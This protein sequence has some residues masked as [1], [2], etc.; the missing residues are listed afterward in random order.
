MKKALIF[1]LAIFIGSSFALFTPRQAEAKAAYY[2]SASTGRF[3]SKSSYRS[4]PATTY[5][6][7]RK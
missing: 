6:S 7:Y 4:S 3:T 2:K 5:R 1:A